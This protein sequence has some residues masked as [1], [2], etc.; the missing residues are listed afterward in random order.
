MEEYWSPKK[1]DSQASGNL[2][3]RTAPWTSTAR[4]LRPALAFDQT[5]HSNGP[6]LS[7]SQFKFLRERTSLAGLGQ[8]FT[9][10][11]MSYGLRVVSGE[12]GCQVL[13]LGQNGHLQR[14]LFWHYSGG[15]LLLPDPSDLPALTLT[16]TFSPFLHLPHCRP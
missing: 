9:R 4:L 14:G 15:F 11:P 5:Q 13:A 3:N 2:G 1:V 8:M 16:N 6:R 12:H 7:A 10:N